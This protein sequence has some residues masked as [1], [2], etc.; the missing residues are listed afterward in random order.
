MDA[1]GKGTGE[2]FLLCA[3]H[4]HYETIGPFL[5]LVKIRLQGELLPV[6]LL[7]HLTKIFWHAVHLTV[8]F[9]IPHLYLSYFLAQDFGRIPKTRLLYIMC[10]LSVRHHLSLKPISHFS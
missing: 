4:K 1:A 10:A 9:A 7:L 8:C 2:W 3:V 6:F 5:L